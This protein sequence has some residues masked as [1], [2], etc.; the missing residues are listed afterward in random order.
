MAKSKVKHFRDYR[1]KKHPVTAKRREK[2]ALIVAYM[3]QVVTNLTDGFDGKQFGTGN[4]GKE[5]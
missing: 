3:A 4:F 5:Y 1:G 2:W